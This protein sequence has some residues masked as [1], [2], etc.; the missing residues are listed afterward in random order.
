MDIEHIILV[1]EMSERIDLVAVEIK[2]LR[3]TL[4]VDK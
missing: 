2:K 1:T 4:S 3:K